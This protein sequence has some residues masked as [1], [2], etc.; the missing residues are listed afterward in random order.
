VGFSFESFEAHVQVPGAS[1]VNDEVQAASA[2]TTR[3]HVRGN[4]R[5]AGAL[6]PIIHIAS[7]V[8]TIRNNHS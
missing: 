3:Q 2:V 7:V 1:L 4:V 5:V 6:R 8:E